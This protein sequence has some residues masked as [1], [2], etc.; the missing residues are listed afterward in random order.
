[1]LPSNPGRRRIDSGSL[2]LVT[3]SPGR[4]PVVSS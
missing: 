2:L 1:M 4:S 3:R